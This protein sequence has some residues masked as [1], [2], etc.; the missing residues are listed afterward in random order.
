MRRL[1]AILAA[2]VAA[3]GAAAP[4]GAALPPV[5]HVFVIVLENKDYDES[6][7]PKSVAPYLSTVLTA[8]GQLLTEYYGTSHNSLGNY[9]SMISGQA[10]NP[11]TQADCQVF[12]DV[13]PGTIGPDGQALGSG[14]VYPKAVRTLADQLDAKGLTWRGY[15][16]DMGRPCRHPAI[17]ERD[18]TQ[19]ARAGDQ[20]AAR[21]NP[22][23]YF[24]SVIDDQARCD[25]G[26][27]PLEQLLPDLAAAGTTP[28]FSLIVPNLCD[29]GHDAPC[30]DGRPGGLVSADAFLQ[31]WV[32]E[33]L[34][35][36]AYRDGGLIVVTWDEANLQE[37]GACCGEPSGLNTPA[38]GIF[39]PGG[40]RTGTVLLSPFVQPGTQNTTPYNHYSLLR[41]VEDLFGL[42]HLGYA[43]QKGLQPF[44]DDVFGAREEVAGA[45]ATGACR[46]RVAVQRRRGGRARLLVRSPRA[47][48]VRAAGQTRR[49]RACQAVHLALRGRHGRARVLLPGSRRARSVR[50]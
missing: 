8:K 27:V 36:P 42:E 6:F 19:S 4:A 50:Y 2:L 28:S 1:L 5:K 18:P 24:H 48:T 31:R 10:A 13:L 46:S 38:P 25:R 37:A 32:P 44:G 15:L 43:G 21:H 47:G 34:A 9:L 40:G 33:L 14:C 39:G 49:V 11:D 7:G 22:F 26:V 3:L 12:R 41:S 29:D 20:Y 16:Q 45:K 35:S 30:V 23:V 17:G